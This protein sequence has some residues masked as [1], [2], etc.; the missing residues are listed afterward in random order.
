MC[1]RFSSPFLAKLLRHPL[2]WLRI[3]FL[4]ILSKLPMWLLIVFLLSKLCRLFKTPA[5]VVE[6]S[7]NDHKKHRRRKTHRYA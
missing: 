4:R 3:L 5:A 6:T 2:R 1:R 7:F